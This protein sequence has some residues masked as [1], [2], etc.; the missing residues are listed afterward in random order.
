MFCVL[1]EKGR[2]C[3]DYFGL[4]RLVVIEL[5]WISFIFGIEIINLK[6]KI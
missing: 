5:Y 1:S 6:L 3:N 2:E 4:N